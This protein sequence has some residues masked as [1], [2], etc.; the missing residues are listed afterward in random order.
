M[1]FQTPEAS[2]ESGAL[3]SFDLF[4]SVRGEPEAHCGQELERI[5]LFCKE[6]LFLLSR[7]KG[8]IGNEMG[9]PQN[10]CTE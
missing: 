9:E 10:N 5:E 3:W 8:D 2:K 4:P 1:L 7:E 6:S